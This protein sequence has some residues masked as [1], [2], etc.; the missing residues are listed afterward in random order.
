MPFSYAAEMLEEYQ[1]PA[2]TSLN[3]IVFAELLSPNALTIIAA[4]SA[5]VISLFGAKL[6]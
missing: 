5:R 4:K 6:L 1:A 2:S 3:L